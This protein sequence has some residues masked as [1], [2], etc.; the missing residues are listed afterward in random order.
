MPVLAFLGW[1]GIVGVAG[2]LVLSLLLVVQKGETRHWH[3]QSDGFEKLYR[4]EHLA[5]G[6]TVLNWRAAAIAAAA[7]DKANVARVEADQSAINERSDHDFQARLA[8]ARAVAQ[9]VRDDAARGTYPGSRNGA[10]VSSVSLAA[11]V[12]DDPATKDRLSGG[13]ALI[14][15]EQALQLDELIR[16]VQAQHQ[17]KP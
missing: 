15:T 14:A 5:F 6:Q 11:R 17:I 13:D 12:L 9:R 1:R 7:I 3:K 8:A 16:W 10:P 2:M 4:T